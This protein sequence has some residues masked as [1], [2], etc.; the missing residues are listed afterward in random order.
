[1]PWLCGAHPAL[2][3]SE[4]VYD[5]GLYPQVHASTIAETTGGLVAAWFGGTQE[6]APDVCIWVSRRIEGRWTESVKAADGVQ[7]DG[8][9]YPTWNPVLFPVNDATLLLF[10]KVGASP[11]D[12]WGEVKKSGDGG[13][14]WSV[15]D[16]LP[17]GIYG[18]IKNK[19]VRVEGGAILAGSSREDFDSPPAWRIHFERSADGG[20]TWALVDVPHPRGTPDVI[21]PS[22]LLLGGR[23]L[24]ALGRTR[25]KRIFATDSGDGGLTWSPPS[26]LD[27]PNPNSGTD[28]L[29]LADGRHLLVYNHSTK[30]RTPL[31]VAVSSDGRAWSAAL[32]LERD[33]G[34]YSYPA[35]IQTRDGLVHITYTWNRRKV[36]HVAFNPAGLNLTPIVGGEWPP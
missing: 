4:F 3:E 11:R 21:Q 2:L 14:S 35:V 34:E 20:R 26:L 19:P 23:R 10:Y 28:A 31:N 30:A 7:A 15:A 9:R 16:K 32:V 5:G 27:L 13:R 33:A 36:K 12:W 29:T 25:A 8:T 24:M 1:M 6:K 18:P 17:G 22:V